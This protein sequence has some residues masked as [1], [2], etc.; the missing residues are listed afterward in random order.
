M[1]MIG[2][3]WS[4]LDPDTANT[5]QFNETNAGLMLAHRRQRWHSITPKMILKS[6]ARYGQY[7]GQ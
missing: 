3:G 4:L 5:R 7:M 2:C 6:R 1:N